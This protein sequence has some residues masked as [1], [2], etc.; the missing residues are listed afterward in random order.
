MG[1]LDAADSVEFNDILLDRHCV[2][3]FTIQTVVVV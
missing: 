3:A 2:I 1:K